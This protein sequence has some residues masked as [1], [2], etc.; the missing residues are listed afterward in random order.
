MEL[1][2]WGVEHDR[3]RPRSG[4]AFNARVAVLEAMSFEQLNRH[5]PHAGL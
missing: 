4:P 2:L 3:A 5:A 1:G